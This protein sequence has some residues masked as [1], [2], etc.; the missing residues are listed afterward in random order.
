MAIWPFSPNLRLCFRWAEE[1]KWDHHQATACWLWNLKV[2]LSSTHPHR[3]ATSVVYYSVECSLYCHTHQSQRKH[4]RKNRKEVPKSSNTTPSQTDNSNNNTFQF[5]HGYFSNSNGPHRRVLARG[6]AETR[7]WH[8]RIRQWHGSWVSWRLRK[9]PREL[10]QGQEHAL[11]SQT[12][13]HLSL[14]LLASW[15]TCSRPSI[16]LLPHSRYISAGFSLFL[17]ICY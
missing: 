10:R 17:F 8:R 2:V 4:G 3:T 15:H 9:A 12:G 6:D 7:N 11:H 5:Y 1:A 13:P 14:H 16:A